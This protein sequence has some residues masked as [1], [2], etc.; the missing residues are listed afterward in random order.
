MPHER[1]YE[2][3]TVSYCTRYRCNRY[4]VN[5][6]YQQMH[7]HS[8]DETA[9]MDGAGDMDKGYLHSTMGC[10]DS[11]EMCTFASELSSLGLNLEPAINCHPGVLQAGLCIN[12]C[13][14]AQMDIKMAPHLRIL[15]GEL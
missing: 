2:S 6:K 11:L 7:L 5:Y 9:D 13:A 8:I 14:V 10:K 4:V 1:A 3:Y 15:I 12:V